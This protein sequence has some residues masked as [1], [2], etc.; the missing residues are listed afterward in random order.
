MNGVKTYPNTKVICISHGLLLNR[1]P[2]V[3]YHCY[4]VLVQY[5]CEIFSS[6]VCYLP[7]PSISRFHGNAFG[8]TGFP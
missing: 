6:K 7:I 5:V 4:L 2:S 8:D 1:F 3:S